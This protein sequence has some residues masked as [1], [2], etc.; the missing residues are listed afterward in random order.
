MNNTRYQVGSNT[1]LESTL[2]NVFVN[3]HT[4]PEFYQEVVALFGNHIEDIHGIYGKYGKSVEE[5]S[6]GRRTAGGMSVESVGGK[7]D[8]GMDC[9]V[10]M[11]SPVTEQS[12]VIGMHVDQPSKVFVSMLYMKEPQDDSVGGSLQIYRHKEGHEKNMDIG[13]M[14]IH[15]TIEYDRNT[16]VFF[17]NSSYSI[18]AVTLRNPTP[19]RRRLVNFIGEVYK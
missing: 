7:T 14:E 18:H 5:L 15:S 12:R 13:N 1:P 9:Q 19:H 6:T 16:V 10:G 4:S 2:W 3:Y 8:V 17:I 11:N